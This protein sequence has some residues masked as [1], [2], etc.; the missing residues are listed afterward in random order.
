M[1]L[2]GIDISSL[3][4][5]GGATIDWQEVA[6]TKRAVYVKATE[7]SSYV[8]PY[9]VQDARDARAAGL[10][11]GLYHFAR[12]D[13][14]NSPVSEAL[15]FLSQTF[16]IVQDLPP[17]L[18]LEMRGQYSWQ[19]LDSWG[20]TWMQDVPGSHPYLNRYFAQ[21]LPGIMR[22]A[23]PWMAIPG[24]P[25][26]PEGCFA[27]Q[28]GQELVPGISGLCDLDLFQDLEEE[29]SQIQVVIVTVPPGA[30]ADTG[31]AQYL[32][33]PNPGYKVWVDQ[34]SLPGLLA[35]YPPPGGSQQT[36]SSEFAG[37]I[38]TLGPEAPGYTGTPFRGS[39]SGSFNLTGTI[40][41]TVNGGGS[42]S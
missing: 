30:P 38:P 31:E 11:V 37:R 1:T 42:L 14:G 4:H 40:G 39:G 3:Q 34:P 2:P 5:P 8:N 19:Q 13:L 20:I 6:K 41:G 17:V 29:M 16:H 26:I 12:P 24:S 27:V 28:F 18:D 32:L 22:A 15:W 10:L 35:L 9:L 33:V 36:L 7:G 25:S 23:A 21:N